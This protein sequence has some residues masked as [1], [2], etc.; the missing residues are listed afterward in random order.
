MD[1]K[2]IADELRR[3]ANQID[4]PSPDLAVQFRDHFVELPRATHLPTIHQ[5]TIV[6][7]SHGI[8]CKCRDCE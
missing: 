5:P 7:D 8:L 3:L 2:A 1:A 4:P 6:E